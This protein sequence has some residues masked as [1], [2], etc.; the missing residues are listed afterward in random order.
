MIDRIKL[1]GSDLEVPRI[2]LG[3]MTFG[4]Q[5]TE[6]DAHLQLNYAFE[7]GIDFLDTAEMYPLP[8]QGRT[9]GVTERIVGSWLRTKPRDKVIVATKVA[10]PGR[11]MDWLRTG[12]REGL[13]PLC[14]RD[15]V[16]ACEASLQ[17]L[18]TDYVDLYQVHWPAR[19]VPLFGAGR[20]DPAAEHESVA[21]QEHLEA[22]DQLVRDGKV[23]HV[24]VSNETPWGV[25]EYTRT[26]G[27]FGLPRI[28]SIQNIYNLVSR[29]F[30][31]GLAEACL[32]ER[33]GL[34]AYSVL[35][36]GF[37]TGKYRGAARPA[38]ARLT[39]FGDRWPRYAKAKI[40]PAVDE[41]AA[42]ASRFG[43]TLAQLALAFAYRRSFVA[44]TIV[45]ATTMEQL[46]QCIDAYSVRLPAEAIAAIDDVHERMPNPAP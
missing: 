2:C 6:R 37:L 14:K 41:Y 33:V 11:G 24:G 22:M 42:I 44:S 43:L 1:G 46:R 17:R 32:H 36:F 13:A 26:A 4:E 3:T 19:N 5:N 15:I 34:L 45:G 12:A 18:G 10:G 20:Y 35:A 29:E 9:Y 27:R 30:E 31:Q 16:L 25:C 21:V 7:R 38:G 39:L 23:R 28:A 8:V 40:P